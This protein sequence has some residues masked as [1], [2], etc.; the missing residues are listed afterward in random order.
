MWTAMSKM[1]PLFHW[2]ALEW[3]WMT[4]FTDE[5]FQ[6]P[7]KSPCGL[8]LT[9]QSNKKTI[10]SNW[11]SFQSKFKKGTQ[12]KQQ[13]PYV[14]MCAKKIT[15]PQHVLILLTW[16]HADVIFTL[17]K[18]VLSKLAKKTSLKKH[19]H[20]NNK[21]TGKVSSSWTS[22][23][24]NPWVWT[25]AYISEPAVERISAPKTF[26]P[27][28]FLRSLHFIVLNLWEH[29]FVLQDHLGKEEL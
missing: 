7:P 18:Q 1:T 14:S 22:Q 12:S 28:H 2:S 9:L 29:V 26:F 27:P 23:R 19:N 24:N 25:K 15:Y 11:E 10:L 20:N 13:S 21:K 17:M 16:N 6:R 3:P 8:Q 5:G 4:S